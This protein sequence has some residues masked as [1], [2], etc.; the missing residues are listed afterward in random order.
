MTLD[1]SEFVQ[2]ILGEGI[3]IIAPGCLLHFLIKMRVVL[4][5]SDP[6]SYP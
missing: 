3:V 5:F 2:S 4:L 1:L 6:Y